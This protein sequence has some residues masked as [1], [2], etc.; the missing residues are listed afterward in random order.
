MDTNI[1]L[2]FEILE[3]ALHL[4]SSVSSIIKV[5]FF[6]DKPKLKTIS[7]K[8]GRLAFKSQIDL[9][10]DYDIL[11]DLEYDT[12][13]KL[14][15]FRNQFMH[16][17]ECNSFK[18]AVEILGNDRGK[19]LLK[20]VANEHKN[21]D[22]EAQ[23]LKGFLSCFLLISK[24]LLNKLAKRE[25][26]VS[27]KIGV[28]RDYN[29]KIIR[30]IDKHFRI[31]KKISKDTTALLIRHKVPKEVIDE[32]HQQYITTITSNKFGKFPKNKFEITEETM[33]R[34]LK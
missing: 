13:L 23:Y 10:N 6:I 26:E 11:D 15:E 17:M 29:E 5:Y 8:S 7:N 28:H 25:E 31:I 21:L 18:K 16:N 2:R 33:R 27:F 19:F 24:S 34:L 1:K 9:L 22:I 12:L 4:E 3:Y 30:L 14:M 20:F 32:L